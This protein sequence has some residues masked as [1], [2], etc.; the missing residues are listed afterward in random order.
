[1]EPEIIVLPPESEVEFDYYYPASQHVE[2]AETTGEKITIGPLGRLAYAV[3]VDCAD[4]IVN[5]KPSAFYLGLK[6]ESER[7]VKDE[8]TVNFWIEFMRSGL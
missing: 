7:F 3:L 6:E 5:P 8:A 1:M 2:R 4:N